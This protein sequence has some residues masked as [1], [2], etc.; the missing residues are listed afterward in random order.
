MR[1]VL[2]TSS[3]PHGLRRTPALTPC[4]EIFCAQVSAA[5]DFAEIDSYQKPARACGSRVYEEGKKNDMGISGGAGHRPLSV[6]A[7]D[8]DPR[9][10]LIEIFG[11]GAAARGSKAIFGPRDASFKKLIA[12][13]VL[14]LLQLAGVNAEI[15]VGG[16]EHALEVVEAER[17]VG[18][19]GA[20]DAE[21]DALVNQAVE[22]GKFGRGPPIMHA[23]FG[24]TCVRGPVVLAVWKRFSHRAS[25]LR[26]V[27]RSKIRKL[28]AGR[29]S[30]RPETSCHKPRGRE[31]RDLRRA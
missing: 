27:S 2:S 5:Q 29:Q 31:Q 3:S 11:E 15:A 19:E 13:N 25:N 14:C 24:A 20:D 9:F 28:C 6:V 23:N 1:E 18:G 22:F 10:H 8:A 7:G 30:L 21:P 16:L 17:L 12:G 26:D 4:S